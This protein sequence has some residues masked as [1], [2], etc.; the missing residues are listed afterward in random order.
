MSRSATREGT[1]GLSPADERA[2]GG[3]M[4]FGPRAGAGMRR[5]RMGDDLERRG[6]ASPASAKKTL[7]IATGARNHAAH[8][9]VALEG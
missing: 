9:E 6:R 7:L 3:P 8:V 1:V 4:P 2:A 5:R